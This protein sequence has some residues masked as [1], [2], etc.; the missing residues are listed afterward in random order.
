MFAYPPGSPEFIRGALAGVI[1][2]VTRLVIGGTNTDI[3]IL[4]TPEDIWGGSGTIPV[5][6]SNE[7]WEIVAQDANDTSAGTGARTVSLTTMNDGY[8]ESTQTVIMNGLTAVAL[9]GTH[10][11]LQ[12]GRVLTVGS[13]GF[14]HSPLIIRVTGGGAIRGYISTLGVADQCAYTVPDN[15]RLELL[16]AIIGQRIGGG[17]NK[18]AIV[19]F[20]VTLSNG[21]K[22]A[23]V[24]LPLVSSGVQMWRQAL[25]NLIPF[26]TLAARSRFTARAISVSSDGT[27]LD[28]Q[29]LGLLFDTTKW[30]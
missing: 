18:D 20:V 21:T 7:S 22:L 26:N 14:P 3:D 2:G 13:N 11:W 16:D 23:P 15:R 8:I 25:P 24:R 17:S 5:P 12:T 19:N 28:G 10:R 27:T 6:S 30:P 1:P 9:T 29:V 4:T